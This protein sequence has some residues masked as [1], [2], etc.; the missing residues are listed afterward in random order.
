MYLPEFI[1]RQHNLP[2]QLAK[3]FIV[4]LPVSVAVLHNSP[5]HFHIYRHIGNRKIFL[6]MI[7]RFSLINNYIFVC[8]Y[9]NLLL[10]LSVSRQKY[11]KC[12]FKTK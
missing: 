3:F 5:E 9:K 10:N 4:Q 7:L 6:L 2:A 11:K 1:L 12:D 8:F